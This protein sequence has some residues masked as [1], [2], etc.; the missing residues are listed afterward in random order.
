MQFQGNEMM[1]KIIFCGS[2]FKRLRLQQQNYCHNYD[3]GELSLTE[4][5]KKKHRNE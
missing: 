3:N 5:R 1:T 4:K 2:V